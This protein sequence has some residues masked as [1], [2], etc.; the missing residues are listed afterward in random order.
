MEE[1]N[2]TIRQMLR[3]VISEN[4]RGNLMLSSRYYNNP[5]LG[6]YVVDET[7]EYV[8]ADNDDI[9]SSV[10]LEM[11]TRFGSPE[12]DLFMK[13]L[14]RD[15]IKSIGKC[16]KVKAESANIIDQVCPI[17][18]ENFKENE[19]YRNLECNHIF[20]KKCIDRWFRK[21]HSD[22]P[23]CRKQVINL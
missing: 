12:T 4:I 14:R 7:E 2:Y 3:G 21:D 22:C 1:I 23:M 16:K 6:G 18:L 11:V 10:F 9:S 8:L 17:C 13:S 19:F 20:H 5:P 15:Q